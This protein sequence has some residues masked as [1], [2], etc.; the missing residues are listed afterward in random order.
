[1]GAGFWAKLGL[2]D[3]QES[4]VLARRP[5]LASVCVCL[6]LAVGCCSMRDCVR[7]KPWLGLLALLSIALSGLTAAGIL[8]LTGTTYNSTYLGVPFILL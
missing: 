5:L 6:V 4:S 7:A 1:M 8:N 2:T 3:F